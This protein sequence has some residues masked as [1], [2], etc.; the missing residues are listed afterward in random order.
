MP[1]NLNNLNSKADKLHVN[2]LDSVLVDLSKLSDVVENDIVK[3]DVYNAKIKNIEDKIPDVTKLATNT[4]LD[5]VE[6]EM[7]NI[8]NLVNLKNL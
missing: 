3:K 5:T 6:N 1:S 7:P 4:T 8:C 2:N